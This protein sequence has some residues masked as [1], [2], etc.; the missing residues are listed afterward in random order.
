[1][2]IIYIAKTGLD[3]NDG[4][5]PA[6]AKLTLGGANTILTSGENTIYV[7]KGVY[8]ESLTFGTNLKFVT[9]ICDYDGTIF[10][11][12]AGVVSIPCQQG[13]TFS[14]TR[15]ID[16]ATIVVSNGT[17][18]CGTST[19]SGSDGNI[20]IT[21]NYC[22][23]QLGS[24]CSIIGYN[25]K[26]RHS[27]IVFNY[28]SSINNVLYVTYYRYPNEM[29]REIVFN[30]FDSITAG[31]SSLQLSAGSSLFG[32]RIIFIDS[33][34]RTTNLEHSIFSSND[35][36][37]INCTL[38]S[39]SSTLTLL[40]ILPYQFSSVDNNYIIRNKGKLHIK[41]CQ[42]LTSTGTS[43]N[44]STT[45]QLVG[46][47]SRWYFAQSVFSAAQLFEAQ[48]NTVFI[49][50]F[51]S[52]NENIIV[53]GHTVLRG[54]T[55]TYNSKSVLAYKHTASSTGIYW[56]THV[57]R[58]RDLNPSTT[59]N[60]SLDFNFTNPSGYNQDGLRIGVLA[61]GES[62]KAKMYDTTT[63]LGYQ[64]W[65]EA[66]HL[67]NTWYAKTIT[68]TTP[69]TITDDYFLVFSHVRPNISS[70]SYDFKITV[71]VIS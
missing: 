56:P 46:S 37:F 4:L 60:I 71:P 44:L 64:L 34:I 58:L 42:L 63:A 1:M 31:T 38:K 50:N 6:T 59:Y 47:E 32:T 35:V 70:S 18:L 19:T 9:I 5:T 3:T 39:T 43:I 24:P 36:S 41:N 61:G 10:S 11:T 49:E 22:I 15:Q 8:S 45:S 30:N 21:F 40:G 52:T 66:I 12:T 16:R 26:S 69:A 33:Q 48:A 2:A 29:T 62:P 27:R 57:I 68:F 14:W 23:L 20:E 55:E 13:T 7:G 65:N 17:S 25:T 53:K 67:S 54:D 51:N 28:C